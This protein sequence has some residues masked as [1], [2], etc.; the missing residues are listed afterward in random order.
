MPAPESSAGAPFLHTSTTVVRMNLWL[1]GGLTLLAV[2]YGA[3]Y[4]PAFV[5]RYALAL[6][7]GAGFEAAYILL[8]E[9]RLAWRSGGSLATAAILVASVPPGLPVRPLV[10]AI[11][12]AVVLGRMPPGARALQLNPAL[13]GRLFLMLA[14]N[15]EIVNWVGPV[16]PPDG[17]TSATP[18]E[19]FHAEDSPEAMYSLALLVT[20][21][22]RG[23][24]GGLYQFV[25]GSPGEMF[26]PVILLVGAVLVW[27]GVM[28]WR[29]GVSFLATFAAACAVLY[30][31]QAREYV[32]AAEGRLAL[33]PFAATLGATVLFNLL[34]GAVVFAAVFIAGAP[35]STPGTKAGRWAAGMVAGIANAIIR[36]YSD[37]SEGIVFSFLLANLLAPTLDRA[38]YGLR[39][40]RLH[41]QQTLARRRHAARAC[42][43][44]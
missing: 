44:G 10:Y 21:R 19:V 14:Y 33:G 5:A 13:L 23:D 27:R 2:L 20:G 32:A 40:W 38:A 35:K 17:V 43:A 41:R 7:L 28:D 22:I 42:A 6:A 9:G 24:W 34:S 12:V 25:P 4:S 37:Y 36:R 31:P 29:P 15:Q 16:A 8:A 39:G 26:T 3:V 1:L 30:A 11:L 18:L